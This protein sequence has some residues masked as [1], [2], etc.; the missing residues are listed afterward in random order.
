MLV[1]VEVSC[2]Q[3]CRFRLILP[4]TTRS[5]AKFTNGSTRLTA[6]MLEGLASSSV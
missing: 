5:K 2:S 6:I 3:K 4:T 1:G